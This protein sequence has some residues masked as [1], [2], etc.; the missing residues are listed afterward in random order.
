MLHF[1]LH[2]EHINPARVSAA[3]LRAATCQAKC[4]KVTFIS[5]EKLVVCLFM[6]ARGMIMEESWSEKEN[7]KK[8]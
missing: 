4:G 6:E 1:T 8:R 5:P 2:A 3:Q 7:E